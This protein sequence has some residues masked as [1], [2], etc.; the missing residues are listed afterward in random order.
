MKVSPWTWMFF[1]ACL[2]APVAAGLFRVWVHQDAVLMGYD[3]SEETRRKERLRDALEKHRVELAA[4]RD[5]AQL[6]RWAATLALHPATPAQ[7]LR[8][9]SS[10]AGASDD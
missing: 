8:T 1:V 4:Q 9:P 7:Y 3:L 10:G 5:P 6:K 2:A